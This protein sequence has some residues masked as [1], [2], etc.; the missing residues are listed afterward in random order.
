[1]ATSNEVDP[2]LHFTPAAYLY[3][4]GDSTSPR[5]ENVRPHD[6]PVFE[7][8]V[9]PGTGGVSTFSTIYSN[10]PAKIGWELPSETALGP[11]LT[12]VNDFGT[13][14]CIEPTTDMPLERYIT[15]LST[16]NSKVFPQEPASGVP[17]IDLPKQSDNPSIHVRVLYK[18]LSTVAR[19]KI[20]IA[21]WDDND[22]TYL[23]ILAGAL[24]SGEVELPS[25]SYTPGSLLVKRQAI[26]ATATAIY[27]KTMDTTLAGT[28]ND[29]E[30]IWWAANRPVLL[31]DSGLSN[32]RENILFVDIVPE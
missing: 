3:R 20:S 6:I 11:D 17:E 7:G 22:Y 21:G 8:K 30:R 28:I 24:H 31:I 26:V 13:H 32:L 10:W 15:A 27:I 2:R 25:L 16:L 12:A 1:F 9:Y 23:A 5:F 29:D 19:E 18:A 14:W 4:A